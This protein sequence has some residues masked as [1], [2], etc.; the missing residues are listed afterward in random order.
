MVPAALGAG[1]IAVRAVVG[2]KRAPYPY[3]LLSWAIVFGAAGLVGESAPQL[4]KVTA[5]AYLTAMLLAPSNANVLKLIPTGKAVPQAPA[6]ASGAATVT[7]K[8]A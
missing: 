5:W 1:I 4:G 7:G 8:A 3:E 6:N 2:Q